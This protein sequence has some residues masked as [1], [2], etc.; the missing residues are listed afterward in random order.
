MLGL[1]FNRA[2]FGGNRVCF[3]LHKAGLRTPWGDRIRVD[4]LESVLIQTLQSLCSVRL[5][6]EFFHFDLDAVL[7]FVLGK[8]GT[9]CNLERGGDPSHQRVGAAAAISSSPVGMYGLSE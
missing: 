5:M 3:G 9:P 1:I 8:R 7:I 2:Y 6:L 4:N